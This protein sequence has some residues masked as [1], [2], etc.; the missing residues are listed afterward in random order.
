[1][2]EMQLRYERIIQ[3]KDTEI[4]QKTKQLQR[5]DRTNAQLQEQVNSMTEIV[6]EVRHQQLSSVAGS[7]SNQNMPIRSY[8]RHIH[9]GDQA[10]NNSGDEDEDEFETGGFPRRFN[11]YGDEGHSLNAR[12]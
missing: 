8:P 5:S 4:L 10:A 2:E 12:S 3:S 11:N 7:G 6:S 9:P 1:M